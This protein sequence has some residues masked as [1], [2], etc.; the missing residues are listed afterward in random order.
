M[1]WVRLD[2][3]FPDD[4]KVEELSDRAFRLYITGLCLSARKL[5]DG[6]LSRKDQS[7]LTAHTQAKKQ[8]IN[9]LVEAGLWIRQGDNLL[10]N[11]YLKYNPPREKV[12]ERREAARVRMAALRGSREH[13]ANEPPNDDANDGE[14]VINPQPQSPAPVLLTADR[15]IALQRLLDVLNDADDNTE[16]TLRRVIAGNRSSVGDIEYAR[17]CACGPGVVSPCRVAVAELKKRAA[18]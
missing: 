9:E 8:H 2:D 16:T 13:N 5:R 17:E 10:I 12:E 6:V 11:A 18:A 1:S 15:E 3:G 4:V 7:V 14:N